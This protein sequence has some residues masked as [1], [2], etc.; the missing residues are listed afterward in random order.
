M[1][2]IVLT[3][4]SFVEPVEIP[5]IGVLGSISIGQGELVAQVEDNQKEQCVYVTSRDERY[6]NRRVRIPYANV[7]SFHETLVDE[8]PEPVSAKAQVKK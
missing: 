5:T 8:A 3:K 7:K 4:V 2:K 1:A 6:A